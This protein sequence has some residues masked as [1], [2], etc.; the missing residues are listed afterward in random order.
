MNILNIYGIVLKQLYWVFSKLLLLSFCA[1]IL[2]F[3][4][5]EL[6]GELALGLA[7]KKM[8]SAAL[9]VLS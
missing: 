9:S 7:A 2:A 5:S 4:L 3:L 6:S 8:I 1:T